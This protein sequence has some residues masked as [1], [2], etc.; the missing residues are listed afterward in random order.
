MGTNVD[1]RSLPPEMQQ[2]FYGMMDSI[3]YGGEGRP[4][5]GSMGSRGS[6]GNKIPEGY[7]MGKIN[8]FNPKQQKLF[9][10]LTELAKPGSYLWRLMNGEEEAFEEG[11]APAHRMFEEKLGQ[12]GSRYSQLAPGAMSAQRGSGF[13]KATG[14][15]ASDFAQ[16]LAA[17]RQDL[18][19][20]AMLD[21]RGL[22]SELLGYRPKEKFLVKNQYQ[23]EEQDS[24]GDFQQGLIGGVTGAGAGYL[25]GG[26]P[27]AVAG[28]LSGFAKGFYG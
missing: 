10:N 9:N 15:L 4:G 8:Q 14:Q 3:N 17:R 23:Q 12:L 25:T 16:D 18:Q 26:P 13:Q 1:I 28:G 2:K 11:E 5:R 7:E 27:G 21:L 6:G 19:R 22:S 24:G 20:Q